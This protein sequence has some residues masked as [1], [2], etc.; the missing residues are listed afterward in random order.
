MIKKTV[1]YI[2]LMV[3]ACLQTP[4]WAD[5]PT[6]C[7]YEHSGIGVQRFKKSK[8]VAGFEQ[9]ERNTAYM[10][11]LKG[12]GGFHLQLFSCA[13]YGATI[14]ILLGP[15][16]KAEAVTR[17]F[18]LLPALFFP[19]A[20]AMRMKAALKKIN[21]DELSTPIHLEQQAADMG[22]TDIRVQMID[23]EDSS[24]LVFSFYGG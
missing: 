14:T 23:A 2:V 6:D 19:A 15:N 21:L 7:V 11:S 22:M 10:G 16:P 17:V 24:L 12:I 8:Q 4:A 13:H 18:D 5:S 20:D 9:L 3:L 1:F